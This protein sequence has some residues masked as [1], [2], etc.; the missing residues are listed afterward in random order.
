MKTVGELIERNERHYPNVDAYVMGDR[1][2]TYAQYADRVRRLSSSLERLGVIRQDRI[3]ILSTNSTEFFEAYGV[4]EW[5]GFILSLYSFRLAPPEVAWLLQDSAPAVVFFEAQFADLFNG[6]RAQ[7]PGV[8]HY[9]C[10]GGPAPD[11]AIPYESLIETGDPAGSSFRARE[12]DLVYLFYTSGTTGKPKGVP[13]RQRAALFTAERQGRYLGPGLRALQATPAFHIGGKGFPLAA[14]W[15]S[16]TIVLQS[17][18]D[19][20]RMM[21]V[22]EKEKVT[23]TFMVAPMIQAVIDHPRIDE[24]DLS[25]LNLVMSASA[26]IP[27][28]L[29]RRA[30]ARM[31]PIF[32]ISYGSTEAGPICTLDRQELRPDGS[33]ADIRRLASVGHFIAEIDGVLLRDDGTPCGPNEIGEVCLNGP[34]FESYW[35][36]SI[37][38]IEA[39]RSGYLH[40]GDMGYADDEGFIFLVDRKKDMIISGGENIY[41]REV[42]DALYRHSAVHEVAVIGVP[43]EKWGEAVRALVVVREGE[44]TTEAELIAFCQTQIA[45]F[46]CPKSILFIAAIPVVGSGKIDKVALRKQYA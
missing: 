33:E 32:Y 20:L 23:F 7:F 28:P 38:T 21:E 3:G 11:W 35:N 24:F 18:F 25:S 31:G 39:T 13:Y 9:V 42:E 44:S 5:G 15:T 40:T 16:G 34:I 1:R 12:H 46:K 22:I 14:M 19:P 4:A 41:S 17:G 45:R 37:A 26:A 43:D 2:V 27:V 6:L 30:I 8:K 36:N 10:I 29:L